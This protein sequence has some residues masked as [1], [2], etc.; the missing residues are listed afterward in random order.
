MLTKGGG[1]RKVGGVEVKY[2][3]LT[4][5]EAGV[6][7]WARSHSVG[8]EIKTTDDLQYLSFVAIAQQ[9][10]RIADVLECMEGRQEQNEY[11]REG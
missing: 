7:E 2:D 9:L 11:R 3:V 8:T 4:W 1:E 5:L 6:D 10:S